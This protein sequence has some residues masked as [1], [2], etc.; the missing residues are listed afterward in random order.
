[1]IGDRVK[2]ARDVLVNVIANLLAAA[3]IYLLGVMAG[4]FPRDA[5][6]IGIA[7][8]VSVL[9]LAGSVK[10]MNS[11]RWSSVFR[12]VLTGVIAAVGLI[13]C[14]AVA[15]L[16]PDWNVAMRVIAVLGGVA[17][18]VFSLFGFLTPT[19]LGEWASAKLESWRRD[20]GGVR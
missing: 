11:D 2:F 7:I 20:K 4:L 14:V 1:M 5:I 17:T 12:T 3:I 9:G 10:L 13:G 18:A 15:I 6:L 19:P 8:A 16:A